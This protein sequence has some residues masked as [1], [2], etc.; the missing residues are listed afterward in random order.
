MSLPPIHR[1]VT[2]HDADG[3]AIVASNGPLPT[4]VEL[5]SIPGMIFH[6]VWET[7]GTPAPVDNGADP[8]TGPLMHRPPKHGTL[9]RFV[10]LPPDTSYLAE[11]DSRMKELFEEVNDVEGSDREARFAAP[12]DAPERGD[13][14]RHR[15]R[16]RDDTGARRFRGTA[17]ARQRRGPARHQPRLGEPLRQDCAACCSSRSTASTSRRSPRHSRG[18]EP[19][20]VTWASEQIAAIT[21][22]RVANPSVN[23]SKMGSSIWRASLALDCDAPELREI[24]GRAQ[25]P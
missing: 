10:D 24:V 8:T 18:D 17:Q 11:A 2:G 1:V 6:E 13:R 5:Q 16:G 20:S 12:D 4:I 3:K 9:I 23:S 25:S 19:E 7:R 21:R 14:L 15:H 22:S